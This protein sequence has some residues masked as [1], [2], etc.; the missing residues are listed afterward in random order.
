MGWFLRAGKVKLS[1]REGSEA[2][3]GY[4][5]VNVGDS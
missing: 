5:E 1:S 4:R 2:P 3:L